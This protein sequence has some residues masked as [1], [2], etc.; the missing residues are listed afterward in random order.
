MTIESND[1]LQQLLS[2]VDTAIDEMSP[3][4]ALELLVLLIEDL[5]GRAD[6]L[7]EHAEN[8]TK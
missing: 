6:A 5:E 1:K 7:R 4:E 2:T 3:P 8:E